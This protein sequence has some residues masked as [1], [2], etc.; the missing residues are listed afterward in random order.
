M[1]GVFSVPAVYSTV[2]LRASQGLCL[3]HH[4]VAGWQHQCHLTG[5][6]ERRL[7][8][9]RDKPPL[10]C[11]SEKKTEPWSCFYIKYV[12]SMETEKNQIS[13]ILQFLQW[14]LLRERRVV[15]FLFFLFQCVFG[16]P[17]LLA[18][19]GKQKESV[20]IWDSAGSIKNKTGQATVPNGMKIHTGK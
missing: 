10:W 20:P 4:G 18:S 19:P 13:T 16:T 6:Y 1:P 3:L 8:S 15:G 17:C 7:Q 11:I 5:S 12:I 14:L 9:W 2:W